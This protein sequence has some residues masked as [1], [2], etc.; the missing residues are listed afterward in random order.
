LPGIIL[1]AVFEKKILIIGKE[2]KPIF[3]MVIFYSLGKIG[4]YFDLNT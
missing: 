2:K 3:E 1:L 4:E